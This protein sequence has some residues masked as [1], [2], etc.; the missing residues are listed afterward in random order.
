MSLSLDCFI[1]GDAF[2][3]LP[4]LYTN[5][6]FCNTTLIDVNIDIVHAC[7]PRRATFV[8]ANTRHIE[9]NIRL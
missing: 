6:E 1:G 3:L 9:E 2:Q 7:S 5:A 4:A 8:D